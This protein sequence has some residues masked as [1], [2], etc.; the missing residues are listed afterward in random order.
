MNTAQAVERMRQVIRRQHKALATEDCYIFWLRRYI[1][2][3]HRMPSNLPSEKKLEQFL[4]DLALRCDVA[5][6]TQ[7]QALHA[8]LYFYKFVLERGTATSQSRTTPNR[9]IPQ[10]SAAIRAFPHHSAQYIF[11]GPV[12]L[13]F[14]FAAR[15]RSTL[16]KP[17]LQ[18]STPILSTAIYT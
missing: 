1:A 3:L 2:A 17:F 15:G 10:H 7:N 11:F 12:R 5:A 6:S 13:V 4:T 18:L 8:I 14:H 16:S 9:A